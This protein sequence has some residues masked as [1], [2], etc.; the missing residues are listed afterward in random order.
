M[1]VIQ[2]KEYGDEQALQ[3]T[4]L[5][6][7]KPGPD[8][9]LVQL[10]AAGLNFIDI[11][12]RT[13]YYPHTLPYVPGYEGAGVVSEIGSK[14]SEVKVGDRVAYTGALGSY[15][16][17]NVVNA[18]QLIPLPDELSFEEGAACPLQ[19]ITAQYLVNDF[20]KIK[21]NDNVLIH[22]A[23]GG[24]GLLL[25]QWVKHLKGR[26]IGT[27][28]TPEKA[29][30]VKEAGADHV[31]LYTEQDFV[32]EVKRITQGIGADYIIDGVGK[33]TFTKDLEAARKYGHICIFGS[34]SGPAE[35]LAPNSLQ[36]KSL[37]I[38][39]GSIFNC[40]NTHEELLERA[41]MVFN[42]IRERWLRLKI[43]HIFSLD[44]AAKAHAMLKG[45]QTSGKIILTIH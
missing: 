29:S 6:I 38:S 1:K 5:P 11:Y 8:E 41:G 15:A 28:S 4:D 24:V 20:Y 30:I 18:A 2:V 33:S 13:G 31:I 22:A 9:V 39:G 42:G 40:M 3:L 37:T 25:V 16:E 10:K 32:E 27:V 7:P 35:A 36:T 19:G 45:R 44:D 17:Y 43:E 21:P 34:A 26:V 12:M 23:A 14:V